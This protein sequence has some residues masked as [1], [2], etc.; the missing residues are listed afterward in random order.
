MF[1]CICAHTHTHTH[2]HNACK[3]THTH[4][5]V[6]QNEQHHIKQ[7]IPQTRKDYNLN[8]L[9]NEISQM[10]KTALENAA[11]QTSKCGR[12]EEKKN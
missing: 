7:I 5:H 10:N 8:K 3:Q 1:L 9:Y 11:T 4:R 6:Y 12:F 2:T